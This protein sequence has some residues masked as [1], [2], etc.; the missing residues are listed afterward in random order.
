MYLSVWQSRD[1]LTEKLAV[2]QGERNRARTRAL[3]LERNLESEKELTKGLREQTKDVQ[4]ENEKLIDEVN[5]LR[6]RERSNRNERRPQ[7]GASTESSNE[8]TPREEK[9]IDRE[10]NDEKYD[11]SE[12]NKVQPNQLRIWTRFSSHQKT[13][14]IRRSIRG[15]ACRA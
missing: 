1:E 12:A 10:N 4:D 9:K 6:A 7:R 14:Y 3:D 8:N 2:V 5:R 11:E 15:Q 13:K